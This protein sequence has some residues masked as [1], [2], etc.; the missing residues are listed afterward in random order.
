MGF[1]ANRELNGTITPLCIKRCVAA[2]ASVSVDV[3]QD[4]PAAQRFAAA[5]AAD[6]NPALS[7]RPG[8]LW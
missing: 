5:G 8:A 6:A 3:R 7:V 1:A 2:N 4:H